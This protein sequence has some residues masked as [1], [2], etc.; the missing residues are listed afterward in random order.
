MKYFT[1]DELTR[2]ETARR[3]RIANVPNTTQVSNL[4]ELVRNVLDPLRERFGGKIYVTSGF[5]SE[6]LNAAVG[7][8]SKSQHLEGKAADI[9]AG[10]R[11]GNRQ[12]YEILTE[13]LFFDQLIV[14]ND[15]EFLH[16]S[17]DWESAFFGDPRMQVL[18]MNK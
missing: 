7:G 17:Y 2:S 18:F 14:Y 16:V 1:M 15:Y 5:R 12:L 4:K 11:E 10:S 3:M 6:V 13:A 9:T 8:S